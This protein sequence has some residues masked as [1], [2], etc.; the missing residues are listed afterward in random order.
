MEKKCLI[1]INKISG[2]A[3]HVKEDRL[4]KLFSDGFSTEFFYIT[5]QNSFT[6]RAADRLVICGGDGTFNRILNMYYGTDT[7]LVYYPCGTLNET[8]HKD[9]EKTGDFLIP[10]CGSVNGKYFSYVFATGTFTPLGYAV[11]TGLK[12]KVKSFAYIINV[13]KQLK[14]W[15]IDADLTIDGQKEKGQY[16]L[17]MALYSPQ[18]FGLRFNKMFG[19]ADKHLYLLSVKAP[20]FNGFFG[21]AEMFFSF[22][23]AFFIGFKKPYLSRKMRF[24]PFTDLHVV[25][26]KQ[27]DFC[28]DG[29][30][31]TMP[32][33]FTVRPVS[34]QKP[35]RVVLEKSHDDQ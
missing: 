7:E 32:T 10:E 27:Y 13:F 17:L 3:D 19:L 12:H 1:V 9:L 21:L 6:Y 26:K 20:R 33:D 29:D 8:A 28:V 23:R 4:Q 15:R 2:K 18:C 5:E 16:C 14:V 30:K 24:A 25:A 31:W 34:I 11:D 35:V 22:F